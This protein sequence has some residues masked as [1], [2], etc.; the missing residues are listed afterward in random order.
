MRKQHGSIVHRAAAVLVAA[1]FVAGCSASDE[2][3]APRLLPAEVARAF[4]SDPSVWDALTTPRQADGEFIEVCKDFAG[5]GATSSSTATFSISGTSTL[6]GA[7]A[8]SVGPVD[9]TLGNG[10]CRE[11]F[12]SE[13]NTVT[14][15][16]I[17]EVGP[18]A[19]G[20]ST[21]VQVISITD[22]VTAT[23]SDVSATSAVATT[24]PGVGALVIFTNN[25]PEEAGCTRTLG[26]WKTHPEEWNETADVNAAAFITGTSFFASG[27]SYLEVLNTPPKGD[28]YFILAHQYIVALL[29]GGSGASATAEVNAALAGASGFFAGGT[30]LRSELIAW[31]EQLAAY[32][33][34]LTGP[35]HCLE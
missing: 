11:I 19:A 32:N 20:T 9:L 31:A 34:G 17:A 35:G 6:E 2:A 33:E 7:S 15:L 16:T 26:Y 12:V 13:L 4:I 1:V 30:A 21:T 22:G 25:V 28:A 23:G 10:E 24:G 8:Q 14:N 3:T 18:M 27:L 29:N 5:G